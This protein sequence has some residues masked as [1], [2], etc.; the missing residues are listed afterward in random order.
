[1]GEC[2]AC[3]RV[4]LPPCAPRSLDLAPARSLD[5]PWLAWLLR[6]FDASF[7]ALL[8]LPWD[9]DLACDA[10]LLLSLL[11]RVDFM[12]PPLIC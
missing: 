12:T 2:L 4:P 3:S 10:C 9:V 11:S 5:L 8:C 7:D 1:M 6:S